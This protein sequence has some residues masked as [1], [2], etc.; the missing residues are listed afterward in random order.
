MITPN[1][2]KAFRIQFA[3]NLNVHKKSFNDAI[4]QL[5]PCASSLALLGDIGLPFC[6]K[7]KHFM[8]WCDTN[9]KKVYWVPGYLELSDEHD[10][11]C[12]WI[13]RYDMCS[14]SMYKWGLENTELC[15]KKKVDLDELQLLFSPIWYKSNNHNM[16]TYTSL[17]TSV[18]MTEND[19]KDI[20][21]SEMNWFLDK[22]ASSVKPV[23]WFTYAS[24][25][26]SVGIHRTVPAP[27][28]NYPKLLCSIQ[29]KSENII[30][31]TYSGSSPWT[32]VN[33]GGH[34]SYLKDA[35]W[36]YI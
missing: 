20:I 17:K 28:L 1:I 30:Y 4:N 12:T 10:K 18:K 35:F 34:N 32:A 27:M 24:P 2:K 31:P 36:E 6:E 13:D 9:Y 33:M 3:S 7:T 11:K 15:Y 16:Y 25:F 8:K 5:D 26:I 22:T 23:A 14:E 21:N 19:F 29:G